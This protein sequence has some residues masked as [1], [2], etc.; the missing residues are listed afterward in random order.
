MKKEH[1]IVGFITLMVILGLGFISYREENTPGE[2]DEFAQCLKN[3]GATFY[4]AFWCSHC[5]SQKELFGRSAKLLPYVECSNPNGQ[6]QLQVC[7]DKKI[8]GYPTWEFADGS[9]LDGEVPLA[10]LAE[11]T[12]CLLPQT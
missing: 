3:K 12:Q 8:T 1:A 2:F 5:Q 11:K 7:T 6:G 10:K 4:G 9:R